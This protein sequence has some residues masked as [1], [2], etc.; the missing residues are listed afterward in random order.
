MEQVGMHTRIEASK[1]SRAL[2][3]GGFSAPGLSSCRYWVSR[4]SVLGQPCGQWAQGA[5]DTRGPESLRSIM[6]LCGLIK[7]HSPAALN[8]ASPKALTSVTCRLKA[9]ARVVCEQSDRTA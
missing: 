3:A 1:F 5:L 4:A 8:A 2:G 9:V 6:G 7:R